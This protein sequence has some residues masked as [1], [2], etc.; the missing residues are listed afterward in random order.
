MHDR[1]T[2]AEVGSM[3][4]VSGSRI[5]TP[6]GPPSPGSTPTK[7]PSTSP[8]IIRTSV[9]H[10]SRTAKPCIN[11]PK[12]SI[13]DLSWFARALVAEG[14][15]KRSL[16]HDDVKRDI[17]GH[18]HDRREEKGG[19]QRFPQRDPADHSHEGGDQEKARDIKPEK[20]RSQTEQ[21]RRN[22]HRHDAPE[23][24][25]C[26]EGFGSLL[27]RQEGGDE[28]IEAGAGKD[29]RQI[30]REIAGL[31]AGRIPCNAGAP[32]VKPERQRQHQQQQRNRDVDDTGIGYCR[33]VGLRRGRIVDNNFNF[34]FGHDHLCCLGST[35]ISLNGVKNTRNHPR[36]RM[37]QYSVSPAVI[38]KT[39][40][41]G[42]P[43]FARHDSII[44]FATNP[45]SVIS[46]LLSASSSSRNFS[47]SLP[48]R[49]IGFSACFSM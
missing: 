3:V 4:K 21:Q 15:L 43:A 33:R 16:R 2:I 29:H 14:R 32:V 28:A 41:T 1:I 26:D 17:E 30:K 42:C 10:V 25:T 12:A 23:L 8:T 24:R 22:E 39:R 48:V 40:S 36:K 11:R 34:G 13:E 5:A 20:L 37:I 18:E 35:I 7:M 19:K 31:R 45:A 27:A 38:A 6:F 49:K 44:Y 46:D 9:F 47:M